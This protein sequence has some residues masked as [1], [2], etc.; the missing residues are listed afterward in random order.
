MYGVAWSWRSK[1]IQN[2]ED[3]LQVVCIRGDVMIRYDRSIW[4]FLCD[5]PGGVAISFP[6]PCART[7][8]PCTTVV[9]T[10]LKDLSIQ[11]RSIGLSINAKKTVICDALD[12]KSIGE[13]LDTLSP[14]LSDI[15]SMWETK[16][17]SVIKKSFAALREQ[18]VLLLAVYSTRPN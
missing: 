5:S 13:Q 11:L 10:A 14:E 15:E 8:N 1:Q 3:M 12:T 16:K 18:T 2:V 9:P 4:I 7:D 17:V 6:P